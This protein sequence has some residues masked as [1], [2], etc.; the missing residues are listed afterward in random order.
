[1]CAVWCADVTTMI[2][3]ITSQ[4]LN[5]SSEKMIP[6][7]QRRGGERWFQF[8]WLYPEGLQGEGILL[9]FL[10]AAFWVR[11][12]KRKLSGRNKCVMG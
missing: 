12:S 6:R 8:N 9:Y 3:W 11:V 5:K 2:H 7:G 10:E 4:L 1:M